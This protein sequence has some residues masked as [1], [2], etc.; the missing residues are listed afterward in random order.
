[1]SKAIIIVSFGTSN[2]AGLKVI[3]DFE[4]EIRGYFNER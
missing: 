4:N 1:M 2:L 3:D